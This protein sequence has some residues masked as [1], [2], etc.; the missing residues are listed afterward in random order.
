MGVA[1]V[2]EELVG[3]I[4]E[5]MASAGVDERVLAT[6]LG[7]APSRLAK[8]G[9]PAAV[10]AFDFADV[11]D[12]LDAVGLDPDETTTWMAKRYRAERTRATKGIT[13]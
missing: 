2:R 9:D 3:L 12:L 8:L 7:W 5:A 6:R 11:L 4:R 10:A 1:A 13:E